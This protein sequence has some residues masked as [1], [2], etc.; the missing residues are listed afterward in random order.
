[1]AD[2]DSRDGQSYASKEVFAWANQLHAAHDAGLQRAFDAPDVESMPAIQ[3]GAAEGKLLQLLA[4]MSGAKVAVEVGTLAGYSAI[5]LARGLASGGHL[6]SIEFDAR[7]AEVARGNI[8]AAGLADRV[9][10]V[11]G[12]GAAVLPTLDQYGPF[13]VVF[14]D[15]D[16]VNYDLYGR[17]AAQNLRVGGMLLGDN[18][19]YF[20]RLLDAEEPGAIA[21][22]RFHEEARSAFDTCC[23][24]TPDGLLLGIKR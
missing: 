16:K 18:A 4:R 7:H 10:V 21:M 17:W 12:S 8:A 24:P 3:V 5:H 13:D 19:F 2:K 20:G 11:T 1:M 15:A 22:R 23:I 6:W 14:I 9:T